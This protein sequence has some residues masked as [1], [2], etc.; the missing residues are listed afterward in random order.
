MSGGV[1]LRGTVSHCE[2][3]LDGRLRSRLQSPR[4]G[5]QRQHQRQHG[6]NAQRKVLSAKCAK[7]VWTVDT[8][9]EALLQFR[10][11]EPIYKHQPLCP[12]TG[13]GTLVRTWAGR[14]CPARNITKTLAHFANFSVGR[15]GSLMARK[16]ILFTFFGEVSHSSHQTAPTCETRFA[17]SVPAWVR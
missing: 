11:R 2:V 17:R 5:E 15:G 13:Q 1:T 3:G 4:H 9:R 7:W 12:F 14:G 8:S 16:C 6:K 10:V